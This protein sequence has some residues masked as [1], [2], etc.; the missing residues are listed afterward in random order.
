M[1]Y[2]HGFFL[3]GEVGA[4][5]T[6]GGLGLVVNS[7]FLVQLRKSSGGSEFLA[8]Q[9]A[10]SAPNEGAGAPFTAENLGCPTLRG[11]RS[12]ATTDDGIR[13]LL[14]PSSQ[15]SEARSPAQGHAAPR[16]SRKNCSM[17]SRLRKNSISPQQEDTGAKEC[18]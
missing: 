8:E 12:V 4:V 5:C 17:P 13:R 14:A 16:H 1:W 6:V 7:V 10:V 2:I 9:I 3:S 15:L 11:F 18:A